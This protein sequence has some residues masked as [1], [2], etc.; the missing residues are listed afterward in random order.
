MKTFIFSFF[1]VFFSYGTFSQGLSGD[2]VLNVYDVNAYTFHNGIRIVDGYDVDTAFFMLD[3]GLGTGTSIFSIITNADLMWFG[4]LKG[5]VIF[6]SNPLTNNPNDK[7]IV[8]SGGG[9]FGVWLR[10]IVDT[11]YFTAPLEGT[12]CYDTASNNLMIHN[13]SRWGTVTVTYP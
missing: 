4:T 1:F 7:A 3:T 2:T 13:G 10:P 5:A 8:A 9:F 12:M 11:T 6:G